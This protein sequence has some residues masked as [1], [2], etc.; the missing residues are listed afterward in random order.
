[1]TEYERGFIEK[2][3]EHGISERDA[4]TL[5]KMAYFWDHTRWEPWSGT[6]GVLGG[7]LAGGAAGTATGIPILGTVG[8]AILGGVLAGARRK[9]V[10]TTNANGEKV[11]LPRNHAIYRGARLADEKF[12]NDYGW[13]ADSPEIREFYRWMRMNGR[14]R[15]GNALSRLWRRTVY[16][17]DEQA[18]MAE[19][20]RLKDIEDYERSMMAS[21]SRTLARQANNDWLSGVGRKSKAE[22]D[23]DAYESDRDRDRYS[24]IGSVPGYEQYA[25]RR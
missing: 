7:M 5:Y 9:P 14:D 20:D 21:R 23:A 6:A 25:S 11:S 2:C 22:I 17:A 18:G 13:G 8:G 19:R 24:D 12:F 3:A 15:P 10:V 1:M 16:S 4:G